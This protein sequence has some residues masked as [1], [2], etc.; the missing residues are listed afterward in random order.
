MVGLL[1]VIIFVG[2]GQWGDSDDSKRPL[3][4]SVRLGYNYPHERV[5]LEFFFVNCAI[6]NMQHPQYL[7]FYRSSYLFEVEFTSYLKAEGPFD[8]SHRY[9]DLETPSCNTA[10]FSIALSADGDYLKKLCGPINLSGSPIGVHR[11]IATVRVQK[12][13]R[14]RSQ[15]PRELDPNALYVYLKGEEAFHCTESEHGSAASGDEGINIMQYQ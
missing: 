15:V 3:F 9:L 7:Q 11:W 8:Q 5:F 2:P 14:Q 13:K 12:H 6:C 4:W 10:S 1:A